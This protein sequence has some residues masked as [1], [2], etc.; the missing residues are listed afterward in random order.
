M[1]NNEVITVAEV[2]KTEIYYLD[3]F[4]SQFVVATFY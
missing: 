1:S 3:S 4:V 2:I